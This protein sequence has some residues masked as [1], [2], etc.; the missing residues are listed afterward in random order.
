MATVMDRSL[1][2]IF[3][4]LNFFGTVIIFMQAPNWF[5]TREPM[6]ITPP[7]KPLSGDAFDI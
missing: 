6:E 4:I 1:M 3:S 7:M 2:I 5:D